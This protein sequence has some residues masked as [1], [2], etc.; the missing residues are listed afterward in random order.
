YLPRYAVQALGFDKIGAGLLVACSQAGG[1]ASRL[2]LGAASDRWLSGRRSL[3]LAV[4]SVVGALIFAVYAIWS[5]SW[6][7]A[8][9][10]LAFVAGSGAHRWAG[11]FFVF[12]A[13]G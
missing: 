3:W 6:A 10:A 2:A 12:G 13:L 4:T 5:V 9:G 11:S 8:A 7:P 1:A